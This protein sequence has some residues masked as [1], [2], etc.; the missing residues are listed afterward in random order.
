MVA[1]EER[2]FDEVGAAVVDG[3]RPLALVVLVLSSDVVVQLQPATETAP[4]SAWIRKS[5]S[6]QFIHTNTRACTHAHTAHTSRHTHTH[7]DTHTRTQTDRHTHTHTHTHT[8]FE[9]NKRSNHNHIHRAQDAASRPKL[10]VKSGCVLQMDLEESDIVSWYPKTRKC[11]KTHNM[12]CMTTPL[13]FCSRPSAHPHPSQHTHTHTHAHQLTW[14]GPWCG[15]RSTRRV[16]AGTSWR[17][18]RPASP[19]AASG[20]PRRQT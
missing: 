9:E 4:G 15:S 12:G 16:W 14:R 11:Q 10:S 6:A 19:C 2:D 7:A 18:R 13:L 3:T 1:H 20:L 5:G 17:R 8:K